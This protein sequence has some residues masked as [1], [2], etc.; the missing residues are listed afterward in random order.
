MIEL[1]FRN[2][3]DRTQT[4]MFQCYTV[5]VLAMD[6]FVASNLAEKINEE[7]SKIHAEEVQPTLHQEMQLQQS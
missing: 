5:R 7:M 6:E 1:K 3:A 2:S 4:Q